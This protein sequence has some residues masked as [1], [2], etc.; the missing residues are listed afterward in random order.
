VDGTGKK[1]DKPE[2]R[3]DKPEKREDKA[4]RIMRARAKKQ[5]K[6]IKKP[7]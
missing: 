2:K 6:T 3:E 5:E 1:G 4:S 7:G